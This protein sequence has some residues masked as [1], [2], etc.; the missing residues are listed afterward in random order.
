LN[1]LTSEN[2]DRLSARDALR[3]DRGDAGEV[4]CLPAI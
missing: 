1:C 3:V 4:Q 2:A